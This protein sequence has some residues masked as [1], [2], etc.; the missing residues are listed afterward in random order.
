MVSEGEE[1]CFSH[2][3]ARQLDDSTRKSIPGDHHHGLVLLMR[4]LQS[5]K[6]CDYMDSPQ[7]GTVLRVADFEPFASDL[8]Y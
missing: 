6:L 1:G 7:I 2:E 3:A 8:F 4:F 5:I